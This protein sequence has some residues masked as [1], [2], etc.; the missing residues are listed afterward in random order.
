M[1]TTMKSQILQLTANVLVLSAISASAAIRYV[2]VN[3]ASPAPPYTDWT[4]AATTIQDA[5]DAAVDG[6]Q[7]LVTNG[8]Y[9]TGE[10]VVFGAM[11]N[12]VAVNKA[13]TV[14]S[15][16]GAAVTVIR[17]FQEPGTINGDSAI[18]C[19]YLTNGAV[20]VGF[21]LTNAATRSSG[22]YLR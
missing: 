16:N 11:T 5:V 6:D 7:I 17:G 18:R 10:R 3:S 1:K 4:S 13:V 20:L 12:R 9:E 22:D 8:V 21:T 15:V 14:Q 2:N 19:V